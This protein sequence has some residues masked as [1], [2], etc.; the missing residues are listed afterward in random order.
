M[1][2]KEALNDIISRI[3]YALRKD[4]EGIT[5]DL[6]E[7]PDGATIEV[8]YDGIKIEIDIELA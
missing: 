6:L 8:D 7:G 3:M 2:K 1:D 5:S 4:D